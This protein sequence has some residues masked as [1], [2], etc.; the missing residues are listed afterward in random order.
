ML[1]SRPFGRNDTYNTLKSQVNGRYVKV[2]DNTKAIRI[3]YEDAGYYSTGAPI[4]P[5]QAE[6]DWQDNE[7][8]Q[9]PPKPKLS[10]EAEP[11]VFEKVP[12]MKDVRGLVQHNNC[13]INRQCEVGWIDK[14][15][16][17]DMGSVDQ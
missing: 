17:A 8:P 4:E 6:T 16:W 12:E 13:H 10:H 15:F 14:V 3:S 2:A 5:K 9:Y 11:S 1:F 7:L